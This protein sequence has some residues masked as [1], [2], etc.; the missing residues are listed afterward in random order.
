MWPF[1][2]KKQF[3]LQQEYRDS[4]EYRSGWMIGS[5]AAIVGLTVFL[6]LYLV[7]GANWY[8]VPTIV[9]VLLF[10][11]SCSGVKKHNAIINAYHDQER[12]KEME[13]FIKNNT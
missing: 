7:Y 3:V 9:S 6:S 8:L 11:K 4:S 5:F 2:K 13:R 1:N 10:L 12:N